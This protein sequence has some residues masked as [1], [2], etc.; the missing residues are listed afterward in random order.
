VT[1][2]DGWKVG[3][4]S[5]TDEEEVVETGDWLT[6]GLWSGKWNIGGCTDG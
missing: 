1:V 4:W 6:D 2:S 5:G 3:I